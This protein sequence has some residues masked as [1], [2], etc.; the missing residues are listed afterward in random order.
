MFGLEKLVCEFACALICA[1]D[2]V[3]KEGR[4]SGKGIK[5]DTTE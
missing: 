5:S 4:K 3:G 2:S 1:V